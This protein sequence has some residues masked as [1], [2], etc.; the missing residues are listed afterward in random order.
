[1]QRSFV[2]GYETDSL[3]PLPTWVPPLGLFIGMLIFIVEMVA[4]IVLV[5]AGRR[6]IPESTTEGA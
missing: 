4:E 2:R 3:I 5:L 1:M 6:E